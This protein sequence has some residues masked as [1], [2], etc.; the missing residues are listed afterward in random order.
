[1]L[2]HIQTQVSVLY[3]LTRA[4]M[5]VDIFEHRLQCGVIT[6]AQI[7]YLDLS[8][9]GPAVRNLRHSW[10]TQENIT[11]FNLIFFPSEKQKTWVNPPYQHIF[12]FNLWPK[13]KTFPHFMDKKQMHCILHRATLLHSACM[14]DRLLGD[15][16]DISRVF[17]KCERDKDPFLVSIMTAFLNWQWW[18]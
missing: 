18:M 16:K 14:Y 4:D 11:T 1:M 7:L 13:C 12:S 15:I 3:L 2:L 5:C 9:S 8:L 10:D 6:N 17:K